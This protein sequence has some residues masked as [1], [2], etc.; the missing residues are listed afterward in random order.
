MVKKDFIEIIARETGLNKAIVRLV[1]DR[2]L[3]EMRNSLLRYERIELR[4]FPVHI[5]LPHSSEKE[6]GT[7]VIVKESFSTRTIQK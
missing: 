5:D 3:L 4:N 1:L 6:T 2:F 7:G